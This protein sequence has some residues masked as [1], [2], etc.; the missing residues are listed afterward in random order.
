VP[1][2]T[3]MGR[4]HAS[5][6]GASIL[7]AAGLEDMV[8]VDEDHYVARCVTLAADLDQLIGLRRNM[9]RRLEQSRLMDEAQ[10]VRGF[11]AA[12]LTMLAESAQTSG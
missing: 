4:A 11:E 7:R 9:R 8:A 5:R 3:L 12:L 10:F 1:V 6:M 2:V